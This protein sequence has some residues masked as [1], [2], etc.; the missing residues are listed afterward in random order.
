MNHDGAAGGPISVH[1]PLPGLKIADVGVVSLPIQESQAKALSTACQ[2]ESAEEESKTIAGERKATCRHIQADDITLSSLWTDAVATL[3]KDMGK[4]IGVTGHKITAKLDK[5]LFYSPDEL[6]S[7]HQYAIRDARAFGSIF[8]QLPSEFEGGKIEISQNDKTHNYDFSENS[9]VQFH[10]VSFYTECNLQV[11]PI[12]SGFR[13]FLVYDLLCH[14]TGPVPSVPLRP[15]IVQKKLNDVA[16]LWE[17]MMASHGDEDEDGSASKIPELY[18]VRLKESYGRYN[19]GFKDLEEQDKEIVQAIRESQRY[20]VNLVLM[21]KMEFD[22]M[23]GGCD[24]S[25]CCPSETERTIEIR[26]YIPDPDCEL[27]KH[28]RLD[29]KPADMLDGKEIFIHGS[30]TCYGDEIEYGGMYEML[31]HTPL[32]LVWPR[33]LT[34]QVVCRS[35]FAAGVSFLSKYVKDEKNDAKKM[36]MGTMKFA[37]ENL[38]KSQPRLGEL[39][40]VTSD[41]KDLESTRKVI[42]MMAD[43]SVG[44]KAKVGIWSER[45]VRLVASAVE[46][47]GWLHLSSA[48]LLAIEN[49][50]WKDFQHCID[51]FHKLLQKKTEENGHV[52][53]A[54]QFIEK[55]SQAVDERKDMFVEV[56]SGAI[57]GI[58]KVVFTG[59]DV[60]AKRGK[61][62]SFLKVMHPF[63]L[64]DAILA[65]KDLKLSVPTKQIRAIA[66]ALI[67]NGRRVE[68][69]KPVASAISALHECGFLDGSGT[70]ISR[71]FP[72]LLDAFIDI[73]FKEENKEKLKGIELHIEKVW[74]VL[75]ERKDEGL[76]GKFTNGVIGTKDADLLK[77][78]LGERFLQYAGNLHLKKMAESLSPLLERPNPSISNRQEKADVPG[79]PEVTEFLRGDEL[80]MRYTKFSNVTEARKWCQKHFG[81]WG[82]SP[83]IRVSA[84]AGGRG[85]AAYVDLRKSITPAN[86]ALFLAEVKKN[87]DDKKHIATLA[88][89]LNVEFEEEEAE[90]PEPMKGVVKV[91]SVKTLNES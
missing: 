61:F 47:F 91:T 72:R 51:L 43:K 15:E 5:L 40:Q 16:D 18:A 63:A 64:S 75:L 70:S 49:T 48:I 42:Y 67:A 54:N 59:E 44:E 83:H 10:A 66:V 4:R 74:S 53:V 90:M 22:S 69:P 24:C 38:A 20:H 78:L 82:R 13:F 84:T 23:E 34:A 57:G 65:L 31:Y 71:K 36:L 11:A 79:H 29:V 58:A 52:S 87:K 32:L 9:D 62:L 12:T 88:P 86:E 60:S 25:T 37:A 85:K 3:V 46:S 30:Q 68:D 33:A 19:F 8:I 26:K 76:I 39:L 21:R 45:H 14:G 35:G 89:F 81:E 55:L 56:P 17:E 41:M 6:S 27:T 1:L 50:H 77:A 73:A 2:R 28:M 80:K 7:D